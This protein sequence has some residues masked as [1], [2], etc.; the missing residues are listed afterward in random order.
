MNIP[1]C[2]YLGLQDDPETQV[3]FPSAINFCHHLKTPGA[4]SLEYQRTF[5]QSGRHILCEVFPQGH[6]TRLPAGAQVAAGERTMIRRSWLLTMVMMSILFVAG[7]VTLSQPSWR[8]LHFLHEL[9]PQIGKTLP[10]P[11]VTAQP[12]PTQPS[13][14]ATPVYFT[15]TAEIPATSVPLGTVA[16]AP[17]GLE[18]PIG[19][20]PTLLI[21]RVLPGESLDLIAAHFETSVEAIQAIN[22]FLPSPLLADLPIIILL[23]QTQTAGLPQ[24]EAYQVN[25]AG[26]TIG[27]LAQSLGVDVV[28]LCKYNL[29]PE[30]TP[31]VAGQWLLLPWPAK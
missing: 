28:Q 7:G 3:A 16:L 6:Y 15:S 25:V 20:S 24:F 9:P 22:H 10:A 4:V 1:A 8:L 31:L 12:P 21:H 19:T 14:T 2:P 23:G 5:C 26:I 17:L 30:G 27:Q 11:P 29:M 18:T 13:A